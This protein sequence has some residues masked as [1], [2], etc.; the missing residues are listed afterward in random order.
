MATVNVT[1]IINPIILISGDHGT[2][3][4]YLHRLITKYIQSSV[5]INKYDFITR[6]LLYLLDIHP[7]LIGY[8]LIDNDMIDRELYI[9]DSKMLYLRNKIKNDT[10]VTNESM[11]YFL[12]YIMGVST[13]LYN[14]E[15]LKVIVNAM[16]ILYNSK[17]NF[18]IKVKFYEL[19][20]LIFNTIIVK[21]YNWNIKENVFKYLDSNFPEFKIIY[22]NYQQRIVYFAYD[23]NEV[24]YFKEKYNAENIFITMKPH[25]QSQLLLKENKISQ[26]DE[27]ITHEQIENVMLMRQSANFIIENNLEFDEKLINKIMNALNI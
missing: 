16:N 2:G 14:D 7:L 26:V 27:I 20:K 21:A 13:K 8:L 4:S 17:Y 6:K 25:L 12:E 5:S 18:S 22:D 10:L 23:I 24:L 11:I 15:D 1:K 19:T 9:N 3:K